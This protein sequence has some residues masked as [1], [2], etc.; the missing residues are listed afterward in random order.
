M[1]QLT[2]RTSDALVDRVR[3][4]ARQAGRSMNEYIASVL[5][6]ATD[7][8]LAGDEADGIRERLARAGLL[9]PTGSPRPRPDAERVA[10]ARAAAGRGTPLS[11]I[12]SPD[13]S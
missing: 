6:A 7:P 3:T 12:V 2:I 1:G 9:A 4:A 5:E 13:R 10:A 8:D 11:S